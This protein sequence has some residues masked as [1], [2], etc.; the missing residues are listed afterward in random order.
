MSPEEQLALEDQEVASEDEAGPDS[1]GSSSKGSQPVRASLPP[2]AAEVPVE[3][4]D[5][6]ML[7]T[8]RQLLNEDR[9]RKLVERHIAEY[10]IPDNLKRQKYE[11]KPSGSSRVAQLVLNEIFNPEQGEWFD[12]NALD[13]VSALTGK[14]VRAGRVHSTPRTTLFGCGSH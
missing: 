2:P 9:R 10:D 4:T 5:E 8:D 13:G 11:E 6:E 12:Q 14:V 3:G 7:E 1:P